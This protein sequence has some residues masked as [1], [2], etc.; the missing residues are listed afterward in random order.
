MK[1]DDKFGNQIDVLQNDIKKNC[2]KYDPEIALLTLFLV[3]NDLFYDLF[4]EKIEVEKILEEYLKYQ[5]KS[6]KENIYNTGDWTSYF[7]N[8]SELLEKIEILKNMD[9]KIGTVGQVAMCDTDGNLCWRDESDIYDKFGKLPSVVLFDKLTEMLDSIKIEDYND[10]ILVY[11]NFYEKKLLNI[12]SEKS[13]YLDILIQEDEIMSI[14]VKSFIRG[15]FEYLKSHMINVDVDFDFDR[16][17]ELKKGCWPVIVKDKFH[18]KEKRPLKGYIVE[19]L[20][21]KLRDLQNETE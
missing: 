3:W 9:K 8:E 4:S 18:E 6:C 15:Y 5:D 13:P 1:I 17:S 7:K 19:G 11:E 16:L 21:D 14:I 10:C 20:S 2:N 12:F